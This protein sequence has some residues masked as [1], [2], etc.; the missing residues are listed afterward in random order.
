MGLRHVVAGVHDSSQSDRQTAA[1]QAPR[2]KLV[3]P[4]IQIGL[5]GK[6]GYPLVHCSFDEDEVETTEA[7]E[8]GQ[9]VTFQCVG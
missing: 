1:D 7:L 2:T 9:I 8:I 6:D 3:M 4:N 5:D